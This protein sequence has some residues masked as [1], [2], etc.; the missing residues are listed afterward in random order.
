M[1]RMKKPKKSVVKRLGALVVVAVLFV[2][3]HMECMAVAAE[4]AGVRKS[5]DEATKLAYLDLNQVSD[6]MLIG[7]ILDARRAVIYSRDWCADD[8]DAYIF[9]TATGETEEIPKFHDVFPEDW[10][11]PL[12]NNFKDM[13]TSE[14]QPRAD[15]FDDLETYLRHPSETVMTSPFKTFTPSG[16]VQ[17]W[18]AA[19]S[20]P[21]D[22][23]NFGVTYMDDGTD[24]LSSVN[25]TPTK[26]VSFSVIIG[27]PYGLR[28]STYS[29]EGYAYMRGGSGFAG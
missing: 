16:Y 29:T 10:D 1:C 5:V 25:L 3:L 7:E 20:I 22:S 17:Y 9:D 6:E 15:S 12:N 13:N 19:N 26:I 28:A 24:R 4:S 8:M 14:I 23:W 21:G 27:I 11:L 18:C 2:T